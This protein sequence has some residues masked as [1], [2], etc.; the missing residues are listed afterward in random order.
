MLTPRDNEWL[1]LLVEQPEPQARALGQV[2]AP[3]LESV[4][5]PALTQ[6]VVP[7]LTPAEALAPV[8]VQAAALV[9]V[10]VQAAALVPG[11]TQAEALA[12]VPVQA[13]ALLPLPTQVLALAL[14]SVQLS[15]CDSMLSSW[16][17]WLQLPGWRL[18][19][20]RCSRTVGVWPLRSVQEPVSTLVVALVTVPT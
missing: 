18:Q 6:V 10:L 9:P 19:A 2:L 5:V 8:P 15:I 16:L 4:P 7:V 14:E 11:L 3:V 12:P 1:I 20:P 17:P 13:A